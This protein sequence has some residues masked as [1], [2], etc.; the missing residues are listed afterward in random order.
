MSKEVLVLGAGFAGINTALKLKRKGLDVAV[1]D[2]RRHHDFLPGIVD[3]YRD[4]SPVSRNRTDL[5]S[6]FEGTGVEFIEEGVMD[7]NLEE[8]TVATNENRYEYENL[9]VALGSQPASYGVDIAEAETVYSFEGAQNVEEKLDEVESV[10]V[11][12]SGY[13]GLETAAEIAELGKQ[14]KIVEKRTRPAAMDSEKMSHIAL[15]YFDSRDIEFKGGKTVTEVKEDC[16]M[17][18]EEGEIEADLVLWA[19][20]IKVPDVVQESFNCGPCGVEVNSGLSSKE[21]A[22]VFVIGDSAETGAVKTAHNAVKQAEVAAE[23]LIKDEDEEL[24]SYEQGKKM[25]VVSLGDTAVFMYGE[26]LFKN[27]V[28]RYLKDIVRLRYFTKLRFA[29]LKTRFF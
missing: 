14:V 13:V 8:D 5:E 11:V 3:V 23:N 4:R 21:H 12:G 17:T 24:T 25:M 16:V 28:F 27:R 22:N 19:A 2:I 7:I 6:F 9:V 15:D 29:G 18:E 26:R 10:L 1:I 20:G